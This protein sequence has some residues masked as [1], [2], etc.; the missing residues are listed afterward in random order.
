M[1]YMGSRLNL[2]STRGPPAPLELAKFPWQASPLGQHS[3]AAVHDCPGRIDLLKRDNHFR[4]KNYYS[5]MH[6]SR[7]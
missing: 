5:S 2:D 3:C 4:N 6:L 7:L 1:L